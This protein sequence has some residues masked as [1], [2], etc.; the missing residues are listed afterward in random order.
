MQ[1]HVSVPK[2]TCFG[3]GRLQGNQSACSRLQRRSSA[4]SNAHAERLVADGVRVFRC[5][6][7]READLA[8]VLAKMQPHVCI[9]DR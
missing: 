1:R 6:I 3:P 8:A 2:H 5:P 9:F 4:R 7:N